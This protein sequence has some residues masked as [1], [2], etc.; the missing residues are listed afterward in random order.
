MKKHIRFGNKKAAGLMDGH[1]SSGGGAVLGFSFACGRRP[2]PKLNRKTERGHRRVV[3]N[4]SIW[5]ADSDIGGT[6]D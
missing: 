3:A 1:K 4:M 2:H 5:T 6:P